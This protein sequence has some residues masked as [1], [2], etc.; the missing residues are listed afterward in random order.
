MLLAF[1][2]P[3]SA[4]AQ[5][6]DMLESLRSRRKSQPDQLELNVLAVSSSY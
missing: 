4:I 3:T 5:R 1:N 6:G 2:L